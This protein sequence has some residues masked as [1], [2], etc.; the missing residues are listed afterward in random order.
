MRVVIALHCVRNLRN[1]ID[2]PEF[3]S[4]AA[5]VSDF[6]SVLVTLLCADQKKGETSSILAQHG[7]LMDHRHC[8][9]GLF[10]TSRDTIQ[11]KVLKSRENLGPSVTGQSNQ[12]AASPN[13]QQSS[14]T[15]PSLGGG[16]SS[17]SSGRNLMSDTMDETYVA[18]RSVARDSSSGHE[19]GYE[20]VC[21]ICGKI[22]SKT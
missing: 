2:K 6:M 4:Q 12:V 9:L 15:L 17:T 10:D 20:I 1:S 14:R 21:S 8:R 18:R 5:H 7:K 16:A 22:V 13:V 3:L 11:L 19:S